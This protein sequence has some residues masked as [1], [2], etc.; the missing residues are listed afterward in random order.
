MGCKH[1]N[2]VGQCTIWDEDD[3]DSAPE[4]C[5]DDG[6]CVVEDD[7]SPEDSCGSYESEDE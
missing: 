1:S 6:A 5:E 2:F 3:L 7:P 4:G